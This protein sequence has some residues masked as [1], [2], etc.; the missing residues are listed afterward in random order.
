MSHWKA[1]ISVLAVF[2]LGAVFGVALSFW[3]APNFGVRAP[4]AQEI[5]AQRIGQR[6]ARNLSLSAEQ[7]TAIEGIVED[8][9]NQIAELRK[10]TRPRV[11]LILQN[12]RDRIRAQLTPEQQEQFDKIVRRNRALI[13][14]SLRDVR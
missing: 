7:R 4:S 3:V 13:N 10:D 5:V 12:A 9:R 8:A 14:E 1:V 6:F 2:I 11:R